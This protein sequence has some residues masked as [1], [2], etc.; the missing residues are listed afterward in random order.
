MKD[1]LL[2]I[3]SISMCVLGMMNLDSKV[4]DNTPL[5]NCTKDNLL[6]N[7]CNELMINVG[8]GCVGYVSDGYWDE[9]QKR[10]VTDKSWNYAK[11]Y[12]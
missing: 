10:F 8:P 3:F 7:S 2:I 11:P 6:Y 1:K 4:C 12:R 9:R 5:S